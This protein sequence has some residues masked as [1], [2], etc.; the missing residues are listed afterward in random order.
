VQELEKMLR[1]RIRRLE[2]SAR[3]RRFDAM[4][5]PIMRALNLIGY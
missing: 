2:E 3:T 1:H 5:Q 4:D